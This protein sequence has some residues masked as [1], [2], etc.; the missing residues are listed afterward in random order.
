MSE[1]NESIRV[2]FGILTLVTAL[3]IG[4]ATSFSWFVHRPT[5]NRIVHKFFSYRFCLILSIFIPYITARNQA[6][7]KYLDR[8]RWYGIPKRNRFW[9][10]QIRVWIQ[11]TPE[12]QRRTKQH[13]VHIYVYSKTASCIPCFC[14]LPTKR[15]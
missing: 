12:S 11:L 14:W 8:N 4:K 15:V 9:Y 5:T 6:R 3:L 1:L 10:W 7:K 13:D 2:H